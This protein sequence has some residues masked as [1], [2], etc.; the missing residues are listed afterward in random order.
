MADEKLGL[1]QGLPCGPEFVRPA[2]ERAVCRANLVGHPVVRRKPPSRQTTAI[3]PSTFA[4]WTAMVRF[5]ISYLRRGV[6]G[7]VTLWSDGGIK[8]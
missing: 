8:E 5:M 6:N 1:L 4:V 3:T 2:L 7:R